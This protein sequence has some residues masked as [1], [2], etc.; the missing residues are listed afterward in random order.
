MTRMKNSKCWQGYREAELSYV[1]TGET[2]TAITLEA[3]LSLRSPRWP[4][5]YSI[6]Q[7][8]LEHNEICLLLLCEF[9]S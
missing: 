6:D 2:T 3:T 1:T 7:V 5:T 4:G 9:W 8:G